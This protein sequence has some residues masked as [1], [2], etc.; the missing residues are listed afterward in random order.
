VNRGANGWGGL[1]L[2]LI[3]QRWSGGSAKGAHRSAPFAGRRSPLSAQRSAGTKAA[4][5]CTD[6]PA[7][8]LIGGRWQVPLLQGSSNPHQPTKALRRPV[9]I[10][11]HTRLSAS[12]HTGS[13]T[14]PAHAPPRQLCVPSTPLHSTACIPFPFLSASS[15]RLRHSF[16]PRLP[17][18][19][20]LSRMQPCVTNSV[21]R[22][23]CHQP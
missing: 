12:A 5:P 14:N 15:P 20:S 13:G 7:A 21:P 8:K 23:H 11:E 9:I 4:L 3:C 18:P 22:P 2:T 6:A 1:T 16:L 17:F 10:L 19:S